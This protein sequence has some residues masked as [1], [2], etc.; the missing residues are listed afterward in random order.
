MVIRFSND[1]LQMISSVYVSNVFVKLYLFLC[2]TS[3]SFLLV[4]FVDTR[5]PVNSLIIINNK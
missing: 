2:F 5:R 4:F 3:S 1:W